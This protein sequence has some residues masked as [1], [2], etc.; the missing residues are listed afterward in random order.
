MQ[1]TMIRL[2]DEMKLEERVNAL[3]FCTKDILIDCSKGLNIK[4]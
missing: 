4:R 2:T 3:N 1:N